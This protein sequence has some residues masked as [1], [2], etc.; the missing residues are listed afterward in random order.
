MT[1]FYRKS[2]YGPNLRAYVL[3]LVIELR[4]SNQKISEH[5]AHVFG[6]AILSSAVHDIKSEAARLYEPTYHCILS[7]GPE[8]RRVI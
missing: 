7:V 8:G 1:F 5:L 3:Y 4:L 2:K 6:V